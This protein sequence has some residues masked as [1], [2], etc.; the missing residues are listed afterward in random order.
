MK[1]FIHRGLNEFNGHDKDGHGYKQP[2]QIFNPPMAEGV[3]GVRLLPGHL[4]A[5]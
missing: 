2:G 1:D 5:H 3:V 4:E